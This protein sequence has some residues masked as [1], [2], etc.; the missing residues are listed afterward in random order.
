ML[1]NCRSV[2]PNYNFVVKKE[3]PAVFK[4]RPKPPFDAKKDK[5]TALRALFAAVKF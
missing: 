3:N 2:Q 4:L 5:K 1:Q